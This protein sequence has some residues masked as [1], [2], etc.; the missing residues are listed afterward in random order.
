[1]SQVYFEDVEPGYELAPLIK[2]PTREQLDAFTKAWGTT[3]G[4]FVSDEAAQTEGFTGVILPGNMSMAFLA[5]LMTEWAGSEGKLKRLEVDFRRSILPGDRLSC[6][7]LVTDTE[8]EDGE[9][10]V[11]LDVYI[12][13]Q[14]GERALQGT[15]LVILP[16]KP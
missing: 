4:R 5:Q 8:V 6:E 11:I 1:M 12:E 3:T 10:R 14:K 15:A 13:T 16:N 9:N 7:G 2:E